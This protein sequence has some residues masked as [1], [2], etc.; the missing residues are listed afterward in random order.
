MRAVIWFILL[1]GAAVVASS[2]LGA[3]DGLV[4]IYG[5]SW[6]FD[7]SLNLF[8]LL[9]LGSCFALVSLIDAINSLTGLPKR[10][11]LWRV[12]RR[13]RTAQAALRESLS[14]YFSG[15]FSRSKAAAQRALAHRHGC[16]AGAEH[17]E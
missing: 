10:A 13:E 3:N 5:G 2:T 8:L 14:Q 16:G 15:R 7:M 1:F 4:S 11:R 9:L 12:A 6:R 17:A